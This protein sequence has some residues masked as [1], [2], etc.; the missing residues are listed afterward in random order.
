MD[1]QRTVIPYEQR[2]SHSAELVLREA[3]QFFMQRGDLYRTLRDLIRRL[4]E[5]EI[6]YTVLDSIALAQHGLAR[7]TLDIDILLT[8]EGL[9]AFKALCVG[10]GYV[11]A[12]PGAQKSFRAADT[13]VCIEIITT[14][15]YPGDGLPKAVSFPDPATASVER[16]GIRVI[17]LERLVELK[18]ASGMTAPHREEDAQQAVDGAKGIVD[19]VIASRERLSGR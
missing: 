4:G 16:G 19:L 15:E 13:G 7:M 14:G 10:R 12:F 9:A 1:T 8:K 3:S 5:A 6:P 2:L 18:L 11:P 17:T